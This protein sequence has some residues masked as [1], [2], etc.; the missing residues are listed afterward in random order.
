M[1]GVFLEMVK[2]DYSEELVYKV[3]ELVGLMRQS[4][5]ESF[6]R[7]GGFFGDRAQ[8]QGKVL[9]I[10]L[11]SSPISQKDLVEKLDMKPQS[12]SELIKKLERKKLVSRVKSAEDKRVFIVSITE[13][14]REALENT[15]GMELFSMTTFTEEEKAQL[16]YLL[17][18]LGK[19]IEPTLKRKPRF[20]PPHH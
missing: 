3:M 10:L 13:R 19:E 6:P 12:A 18:K 7:R 17:D 9:N 8:G 2:R 5:H 11:E 20:H 16:I 14:G 4:V 1:K 15:E